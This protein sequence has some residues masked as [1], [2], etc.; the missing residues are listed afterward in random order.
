MAALRNVRYA[1]WNKLLTRIGVVCDKMKAG[2]HIL[3]GT[4][5]HKIDLDVISIFAGWFLLNDSNN[6]NT[7]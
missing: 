2:S 6:R 3:H 4:G 7:L 1:R 5:L